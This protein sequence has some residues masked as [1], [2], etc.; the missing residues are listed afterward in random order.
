MLKTHFGTIYYVRENYLSRKRPYKT[1]QTCC[2]K[3]TFKEDQFSTESDKLAYRKGYLTTLRS[4]YIRK[5]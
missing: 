2:N 5:T 4:L 1:S 3:S